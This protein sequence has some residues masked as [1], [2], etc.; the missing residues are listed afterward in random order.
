MK[1]TV[2]FLSAE[3]EQIQVGSPA[4]LTLEDTGEELQGIVTVVSSME[5]TL[6]GGRL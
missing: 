4:V 3:A 1:L 5:E 6:S 2:P